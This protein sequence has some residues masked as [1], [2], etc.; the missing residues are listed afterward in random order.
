MKINS[1]FA[2]KILKKAVKIGKKAGPA[3]LVSLGLGT[4]WGSGFAAGTAKPKADALI[5]AEKKKQGVEKL[6]VV[7]TVKTTW[8][9]YAPAAAAG[10]ASIA[11][12]GAGVG[13][14]EARLSAAMTALDKT[15]KDFNDYKSESEKVMT[16]EQQ[17]AVETECVK[18]KAERA[19]KPSKEFESV[20]RS[21]DMVRAMDSVTNLYFWIRPNDI[22]KATTDINRKLWT[23]YTD[24]EGIP[25][26]DWIYTLM[27]Y[28]KFDTD[29]PHI[30]NYAKNNGYNYA[31]TRELK[32]RTTYQDENDYPVLVVDPKREPYM[33][34]DKYNK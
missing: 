19:P 3:M 14:E 26:S 29:T 15:V 5:E 16:P 28:G 24:N 9:V 8:K 34:W 4:A 2:N 12:A 22:E 27:E 11:L 31:M 13:I 6:S 23:A 18:K 32:F 30:P 10:A 21:T 33:D 7:D 25:Y 1:K 20:E 17:K